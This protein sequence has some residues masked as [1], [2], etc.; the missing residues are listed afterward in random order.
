MYPDGR[1]GR[2]MNPLTEARQALEA[3]LKPLGLNVYPAPPSSITTPAAIITAG[4]PWAEPIT[5]T[6]TRVRWSVTITAGQLG[7]SAAA[8]EHLE[9]LVWDLVAAVR[10]GGMEVGPVSSIRSQRYGQAEVAA[11]DVEVRVSVDD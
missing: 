5:W 9:Q 2:R 10:A 3:T 7:E 11:L 8:Y 6:R 1:G 4:D